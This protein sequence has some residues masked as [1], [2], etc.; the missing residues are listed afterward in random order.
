MENCS[1][2]CDVV[3][4][5]AAVKAIIEIKWNIFK[6]NI[7][8]LINKNFSALNCWPFEIS[9]YVPTFTYMV[10]MEKIK[11]LPKTILH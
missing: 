4:S 7:Q 2:T 1:L 5:G 8:I 11:E 3:G 6:I 9:W 10:T